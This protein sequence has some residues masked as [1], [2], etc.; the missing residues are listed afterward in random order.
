MKSMKLGLAGLSVLASSVVACSSTTPSEQAPD[1][2]GTG[3]ATVTTDSGP[4]DDDA[5]DA[6]PTPADAGPDADG[7]AT[8]CDPVA[9][10][11]ALLAAPIAPLHAIANLD[12]NETAPGVATL[13]YAESVNCAPTL[14]TD[15]GIATQ[16]EG[17]WGANQDVQI[18]FNAT[19]PSY[20]TQIDLQGAYTGKISFSSRVGGAYGNHTYAIGIGVLQRDGVAMTID[21]A[22]TPKTAINEIFDGLVATFAPTYPAEVDCQADNDC[23]IEPHDDSNPDGGPGNAIVGVRPVAIYFG[24]PSG[25]STPSLFYT[26]FGGGENL[27]GGPG[28][29]GDGGYAAP[30]AGCLFGGSPFGSCESPTT[31]LCSNQPGTTEHSCHDFPQHGYM[32]SCCP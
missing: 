21:W 28:V 15:S 9:A 20:V 11:K 27:D 16:G 26:F 5:A 10:L 2:A 17:Y 12:M 30:P 1:D 4:G 18:Y 23:L 22:G 29:P 7:S 19:A 24:M 3:D 8:A 31:P 32:A 13:A 25:T 14:I 6:N